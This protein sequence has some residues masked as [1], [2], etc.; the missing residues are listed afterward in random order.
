[1]KV[2]QLLEGVEIVSFDLEVDF[3]ENI[4]DISFDSRDLKKKSPFFAFK[5]VTIDSH[6]FAKTAYESGK[7]PFVVAEHKIEGVPTVVVAD[8][9]KALSLACRNYFNCPDLDMTKAAVTG[10]NG[11][12]TVS[13][14]IES[15]MKAA[16]SKPV[17][18]GTTGVSFAG[19][20]I[21]LDS[22][23]P[24]P[25]DFW[26]VL[27]QAVDKGCDS[28]VMEV[29]SH[30]LDQHRVFGIVFDVAIFTNLSGDHLDYHKTMDDYFEAKQ[31]LFTKEYS[32]VGAI[33]TDNEYGAELAMVCE[34]DKVTYGIGPKTDVGAEE[35]W[36]DL[37]GISATLVSPAGK[38]KLKSHLVGLHNLENILSAAAGCIMI[39]ISEENIAKGIENLKNV[40]GRLEKFKKDNGA[41][42]FVD[43]AHT[44][45]ALRNVLEALSNFRENR[46]ITVFGCGGDRDRTKRPRMAKAAED[47]SDIVIVTNDNPRTEDPEQIFGDI[48]KGFK[49]AESV[50]ITPDRRQA[51]CQAVEMAED[52]DIILVAGKGHEDYMIIGTEKVHFDDREE[53]RNCL[54]GNKC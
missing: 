5:G 23:T 6:S 2:S 22:T 4:K 30:A 54:E 53:I 3:E 40:P 47:N 11:K 19:E 15:I 25:Y 42:I 33:G 17:K 31:I 10:T 21:D 41:F 37:D 52:K 45:D 8:G 34:V 46:I 16:G 12:T 28:L 32:N 26:K 36:F 39:G 50:I 48:L 43:Y 35:I 1:M 14:I 9:R 18:V 20:Y 44:D 49:N 13:Y 38:I 24:S 7:V 51:I 27:R 29:S